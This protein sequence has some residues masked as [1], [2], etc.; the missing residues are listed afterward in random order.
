MENDYFV[1][2]GI[3]STD[4]D[5]YLL[6]YTF[7]VL[8]GDKMQYDDSP[9][10]DGSINNGDESLRDIVIDCRCAIVGE[11]ERDINNKIRQVNY[12][13]RGFG[14]LEFWDDDK[15]YIGK[16]NDEV[17]APIRNEDWYEFDLKFRCEPFAFGNRKT[18]KLLTNGSIINNGTEETSMKLKIEVKTDTNKIDI[19]ND[20]IGEKIYITDDFNTGDIIEI[21][22]EN[23]YQSILKNGVSIMDK[24]SYTSI[25]SYFVLIPGE[26]SIRFNPEIEIEFAFNERWVA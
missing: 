6:G 23:K 4:H 11:S 17:I 18:P 2:K 26:N 20:T 14:K 21:D 1:F 7:T 3:K 12:Q 24:L 16:I 5:I 9:F 8:P 13:L 10:S 15:Y 19:T 25:L 22:M